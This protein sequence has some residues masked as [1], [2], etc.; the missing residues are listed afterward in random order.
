MGSRD[1]RATSGLPFLFK[2]TLSPDNR[3]AGL[4]LDEPM[5]CIE[6]GSPN[7]LDS[8]RLYNC[9]RARMVRVETSM[10]MQI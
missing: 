3:A 8:Q 4:S 5:T 1:Y 2:K 6:R 10:Q 9:D 7:V